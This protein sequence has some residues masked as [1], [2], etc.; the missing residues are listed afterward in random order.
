MASGTVD[1]YPSLGICPSSQEFGVILWEGWSRVVWLMG[2]SKKGIPEQSS[3]YGR[4]DWKIQ[5]VVRIVCIGAWQA[6]YAGS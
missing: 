4:G 5:T 1:E 6:P 3:R 2:L